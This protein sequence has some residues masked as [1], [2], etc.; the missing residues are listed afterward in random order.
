MITATILC[1]SCAAAGITTAAEEPQDR[2]HR[3]VDDAIRPLM[4]KQ[5]I[6]GMAVGL[7]VQGQC[8]VFNY[9]VASKETRH[10]VTRD[11]L[12]E[13]GSVTKT[14]TATLT[15]WAQVNDRLLLSDRVAKYLP[16]LRTS[17][18]GD[19]RLLHLGTHTPGGLPLQVP[20]GI[21][22][23]DQLLGYLKKWRPTY[24]P[25]TYRTYNNPGI[26]I[27]GVIAAK[28][29]G[30]PYSAL[31]ERRI[32]PALGM[33]DTFIAVPAIR[34]ADYAQGYTKDG[35]PIRLST[36]ILSS[37]TYGIKTTAT[38]LIRFIKANMKLVA[39]DERLQRAII[40]THIGYFKAGVMT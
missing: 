27:L 38:D 25:G 20:D 21:Q 19:L 22:S 39:L 40:D 3:V 16:A 9:G 31:M 32:F 1:C 29:L 13:I 11:T 23:D 35:A 24:P 14:F 6:P 34:M 28:S 37:E 18:F 33:K 10:A 36:G 12:F 2:L 4:T 30:Q 17:E 15:S 26:G 7:L 5:D 8:A